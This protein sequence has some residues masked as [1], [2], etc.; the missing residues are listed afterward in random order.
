MCVYGVS[1][2]IISDYG[3]Q[4]GREMSDEKVGG[5]QTVGG[6]SST[7]KESQRAVDGW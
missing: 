2:Y 6:K 1:L 5:R 3:D 7:E 4:A